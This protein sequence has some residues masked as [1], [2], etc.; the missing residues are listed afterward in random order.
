[1]E[2]VEDAEWEGHVA[3]HCPLVGTV[4]FD[5]VLLVVVTPDQ[6]RLHDVDRQ[7]GHNEEGD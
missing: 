6:Q 3:Q 2:P 1:M 7:V 4:E 5:L